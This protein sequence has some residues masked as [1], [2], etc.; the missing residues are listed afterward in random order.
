VEI[1]GE[2][3]AESDDFVGLFYPNPD[4]SRIHCLNSKLA[5]AEVTVRIAGR[6]ARAFRSSRAALE[7]GTD[8][9]HHG[10]RMYL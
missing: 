4:G 6:P 9:P 1:D 8:D 5:R 2:M 7:I 10:V 3:W